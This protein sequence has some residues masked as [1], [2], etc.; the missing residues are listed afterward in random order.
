[1]MVKINCFCH[2]HIFFIGCNE[3]DSSKPDFGVTTCRVYFI[4]FIYVGNCVPLALI[5][6]M[7]SV[8]L[9]KKWRLKNRCII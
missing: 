8:R 9:K 1:M 2:N 6:Y 3:N 5:Q 4:C 7:K